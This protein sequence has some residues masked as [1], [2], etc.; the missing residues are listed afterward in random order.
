MVSQIW[1]LIG[2]VF[3]GYFVTLLLFPGLVAEV[4]N[5]TLGS[6]TP[7]LLIAIFNYTDFIAKYLALIPIR[8]S[9]KMLLVGSAVRIVLIPLIVMCV[10]PSPSSPVFGDTV[11]YLAGAFVLVLG[12]SNGYFGSLPLITA[13]KHVKDD[14]NKELAGVLMCL[15]CCRGFGKDLPRRRLGK[16]L[17]CRLR[18]YNFGNNRLQ[19]FHPLNS[20]MHGQS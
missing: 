15:E 4:Q 6:W 17:S 2:A 19:I 12:L 3:A 5:C 9:P 16:R 1:P 14:R 11:I 8:W 10:T 13:P 20:H 18:V 7:I